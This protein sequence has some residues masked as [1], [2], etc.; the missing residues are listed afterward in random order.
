MREQEKEN[1]KTEDDTP[2]KWKNPV[3]LPTKYHTLATITD[4]KPK[5]TSKEIGF[6]A[7]GN[8]SEELENTTNYFQ[9]FP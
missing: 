2:T 7:D 4:E 5:E 8:Q 1:N 6:P 9:I 3:T